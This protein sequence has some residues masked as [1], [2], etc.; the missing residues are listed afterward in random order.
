MAYKNFKLTDIK[1]KFGIDTIFAEVWQKEAVL[2][3]EPS[4][5]LKQSLR[6]A[7][8]IPLTTE[9]ALSERVVSPVLAEVKARNADKIQI[10]SGETI[11]ADISQGLNGEID[12]IMVKKPYAPEPTAPI[13][14]VTE[15]KVG[16]LDKAIP[17]AAAQMIGS[18][19][20]NKNNGDP[21]ET[22]HS[23]VT[24]GNSWRFLRL[25]NNTILVDNTRY[26]LV[27]I[28]HILGIFQNIV[29]FYI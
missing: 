19:L 7:D 9:K 27:E 26:S 21:I 1:Q 28:S 3:I 22:L 5:F 16:R 29:D 10:F 13:I 23:V 17:Q 25:E 18:R 11:S 14:A 20:F 8:L 6:L 24:D 4:D 2:L 15:A 12:F